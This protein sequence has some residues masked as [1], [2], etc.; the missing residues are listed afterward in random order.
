MRWSEIRR[1]HFIIVRARDH[2][3]W[4][5]DPS[6]AGV[7]GYPV[8][9]MEVRGQVRE[10]TDDHVTIEGRWKDDGVVEFGTYSI[11]REAVISVRRMR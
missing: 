3:Q 6:A 1:R 10:I 4:M 8:I 2:V 5:R 9:E 7:K 11:L